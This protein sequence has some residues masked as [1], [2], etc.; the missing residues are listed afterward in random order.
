MKQPL[1]IALV[2]T[3]VLGVAASALLLAL[4][5]LARQGVQSGATYALQVP[6]AV[7]SM[8]IELTQGRLALDGMVVSNPDGFRSAHLMRLEHLDSQVEPAS[9]FSGTMVLTEFRIKGLEINIEQS[10]GGLNTDRVLASLSRLGRQGQQGRKIRLDRVVLE[11]VRAN[12]YPLG[13]QRPRVID[14]PPIE[15]NDVA[16]GSG[17]PVSVIVARILP[18]VIAAVLKQ[19]QARLVPAWLQ[20]YGGKTGKQ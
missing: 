1:K 13:A 12:Y 11:G 4:D 5:T 2:A 3:A 18:A 10:S 20:S 15:L 14:V 17:Q 16:A 8:S 9:I 19:E 6:A 7:E